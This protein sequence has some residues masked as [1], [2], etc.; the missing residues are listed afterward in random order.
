MRSAG[1]AVLALVLALGLAPLAG[2]H[3]EASEG[4]EV[5]H[6]DTP[7]ELAGADI[8]DA[9]DRAQLTSRTSAALPQ[10][11]PTTWCGTR[12]TDDDTV[13]AA[14]PPS[15]S[16]IKVVYAYP[17]DL[18]DRSAAWSDSLQADVSRIEQYLALQSGGR[19]ALRFDM[20][21]NCGAQYV[22]VQVV[23]LQDPRS[24]YANDFYAVAN[25]VNSQLS[26]PTGP[27]DVFI[28]ADGLSDDGTNPADD[29]YGIGEVYLNPPTPSADVAGASNPHNL[30]GMTGI[31]FVEPSTS[32]D[33]W[34]WQPTVMLHEMT[35]NLGGVQLSAPH[36]TDG[37]HCTDG[38]DVM[39]YADGSS[40]QYNPNVCP[41]AGGAIPQTYDC[42][43]NDYYNPDPAGGSYLAT[44]WNVYNSVF[45]A[46]CTQLGTACGGDIVPTPP[47][48]QGAPTVIGTP[49]RGTILTATLGSWLNVPSSY[50]I[51]WQRG[52]NGAWGDI[53]GANASA[54]V[55]G[56]A[57]I[58]AALRV[59]VTAANAD[60]AAVAASA[61]TATVTDPTAAAATQPAR[62]VRIKL[63]NGARHLAGTLT[64][65]VRNVASGR[66]VSTP[67]T[68]VSLPAGTW[69][70][71]LCAGRAGA[72]P[73]C[74]TTAKVR[75]RKRGVRLPAAKVVVGTAGTLKVT[76]SAL[77]GKRRVR[78]R[79]Q[80]A[81]D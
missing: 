36:H 48:N 3:H 28:L 7:A 1:A 22:D 43:H 65:K 10:Y 56:P 31:M 2:A 17:S 77:D 14:F 51:Q 78:A 81:S 23:P 75:S 21:T 47:V 50:A 40:Q 67:A 54:Y 66:E 12:R 79:G 18:T 53:P 27:R 41:V 57:D 69:R 70:L 4:G 74:T 6:R 73:R 30:G 68:K 29:V 34:D 5:T 58:A 80:A 49:H 24:N 15:A 63:R 59:V 33:A 37:A 44:H 39:C 71:K 52:A 76:A 32:P 62:T 8:G 11:L 55:A 46:S 45:M 64:A 16:Q 19:R 26:A 60:G 20:G 72:S 9:L 35:H 13:H 25:E 42:G 61:P 38:R